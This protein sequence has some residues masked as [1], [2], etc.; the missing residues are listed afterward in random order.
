LTKKLTSENSKD[1]A[2]EEN[3]MKESMETTLQANKNTLNK[4]SMPSRD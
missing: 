3:T 1:Q 4:A 2:S